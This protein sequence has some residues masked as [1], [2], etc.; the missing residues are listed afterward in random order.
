MPSNGACYE[1]D[2]PAGTACD[3]KTSCMGPGLCD[4][5]GRC[6]GSPAPNGDTCTLTGGA[7]GL[8]VTGTCITTDDRL[9][10][11]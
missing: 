11:P 7:I 8:C 4:D 1:M 3:P 2:L 5:Q 6:V 9:T 10:P